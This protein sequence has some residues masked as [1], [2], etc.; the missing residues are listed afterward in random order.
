MDNDAIFTSNNPFILREFVFRVYYFPSEVIQK[1]TRVA[2]I[3]NILSS[4]MNGSDYCIQLDLI[5]E[6]ELYGSIGVF[7][8]WSVTSSEFSEFRES[9]ESLNPVSWS[10]L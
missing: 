6:A 8:K 7:S 3:P 1:P 9:E 10:F 5:S 4:D 2:V